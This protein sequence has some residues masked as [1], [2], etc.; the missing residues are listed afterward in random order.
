M[1]ALAARPFDIACVVVEPTGPNCPAAPVAEV[2]V[3]AFD[4]RGVLQ[5]LVERCSVVTIELEAV[6]VE[7]ISWL[8]E[9]VP[10][11]PG[12]EG[13]RAAQ[14]R[15][16]EKQLFRS[17]GIPT[18]P[19]DDEVPADSP[20][21]VKTRRGG[22]DG[23]GQIRTRTA[24][25]RTAALRELPDPI[26]EGLVTFQR[27]LSLVAARSVSG[28]ISCY[29]L[30]E[31]VHVDGILR[32]TMAP[33]RVTPELQSQ[34]EHIAH[35]LLEH[36]GY[37]GV[38]GI[39]LFDVDG[40]LVV[41]EFAPRVHNT[42]HWTIEGSATSQF[43]QHVRAVM[44]LPLGDVATRGASTMINAIGTLPHL[45]SV[46]AIPGCHMHAYGKENRP[47]RKVGHITVTADDRATV[48]DRVRQLRSSTNH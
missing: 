4:D 46:L 5:R 6:P 48:E 44:D 42:G 33:A 32:E 16:L 35:R 15:L 23:R 17:L 14:D 37:V 8:A 28:A 41:N 21:I 38:I 36:V 45:L 29:P 47:G 31:N 2:I 20:A 12:V 27:E 24:D 40:T 1:I 30:V 39:E 43:E 19:F 9:R 11:R 7:A 10:V 13:I 25:E 22:Y 34:A 3:G 26:V 18:A